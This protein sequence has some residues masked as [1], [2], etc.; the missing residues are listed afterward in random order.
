LSNLIAWGPMSNALFRPFSSLK[1]ARRAGL[2]C[3]LGASSSPSLLSRWTGDGGIM[4]CTRVCTSAIF[5]RSFRAN[6]TL[7]VM[8]CFYAFFYAG[9]LKTSRA[10]ALKNS[11]RFCTSQRKEVR[12]AVCTRGC[13]R[14]FNSLIRPCRAGMTEV[15]LVRWRNNHVMTFWTAI[16][17][18]TSVHTASSRVVV[19]GSC[20]KLTSCGARAGVNWGYLRS[21]WASDA[22]ITVGSLFVCPCRAW[23]TRRIGF[24][25][26]I[27]NLLTSRA[28]FGQPRSAL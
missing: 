1:V 19:R 15:V 24:P 21:S 25:A 27:S 17:R 9:Y 18:F 14:V 7:P 4:C 22:L 12:K 2:A 20:T 5:K 6:F 10:L 13:G 23:L 16:D 11:T 8:G 3:C 28:A 26:L